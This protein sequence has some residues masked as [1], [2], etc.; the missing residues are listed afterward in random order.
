MG[1]QFSIGEVARLVGVTTQTLKNWESAGLLPKSFRVGLKKSRKWN[2]LQLALI[3]EF[4]KSN[5]YKRYWD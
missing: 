4:A 2:E 3:L 5:G 1:R